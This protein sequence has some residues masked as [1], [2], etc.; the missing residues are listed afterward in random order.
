M[1]YKLYTDPFVLVIIGVTIVNIVFGIVT[2]LST[3]KLKEKLF[4]RNRS[5]NPDI[6]DRVPT[7]TR[8][9]KQFEAEATKLQR[10]MNFWFTLFSN[11]T[12]M[13]PLLGMLGTVKS[14]LDLVGKMSG[15]TA[16]TDQFF[17]ALGTTYAG[18]ITALLCKLFSS[19]LSPSVDEC[20]S[21]ITLL[22]NV[23]ISKES[24]QAEKEE[25]PQLVRTGKR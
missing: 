21:E 25:L 8:E 1:E 2:H 19:F 16:P 6:N 4:P 13:L 24:A 10:P 12:T 22:R 9:L 7:N 18:L 14:L 17:T 5:A 11:I 15:D 3:K 20:N 23:L